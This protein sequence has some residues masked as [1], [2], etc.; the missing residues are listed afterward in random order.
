MRRTRWIGWSAVPLILLLA[1]LPA[2]AAPAAPAAGSP[3]AQVPADAPFVVYVH[4]L[5]RTQDRLETMIKNA[6]PDLGPKVTDQMRMAIKQLFQNPALMGRE[7]K[8]LVKDGAI[9]VVS[10]EMPAPG[11]NPPKVA[12]LVPVKSYAE[13]RDSVLQDDE[14]KNLKNDSAGYE[15]TIVNNEDLYFIDRKN[16]Y[17]AVTP[18]KEVAAMLAK[19]T[20]TGLD[21]KLR[22]EMS[23]KLLDADVGLYVDMAAVNKQYGDVIKQSRTT[24]EEQLE[25]NTP[26]KTVAE[27]MKRMMGPMF[28]AVQDSTALLVTAEFRPAG[29][30]LHFQAAVGEDT[31]SNSLLRDS[32]PSAITETRALPAGLMVYSAMHIRPAVLEGYGSLV[33]S[34]LADPNSEEGKALKGALDELAAAKPSLVVTASDV[35]L[36]G[37]SVWTFG[38][39]TKAADAQ[40]KLFKALKPGVTAA[41]GMLKDAPEVKAKAEKYEGFEFNSAKLTW[42]LEKMVEQQ[43]AAG[44]FNEQQKKALLDYQKSMLGEGTNI[45]FG[46]DGKS[47]LQVTAK[48]W[49]TAQALIDAYLQAKSKVGDVDAYKDARQQL[50]PDVTI[51]TMVDLPLY[52]QA[53]VE[54]I[55]PLLQAGGLPIAIPAPAGKAKT[56]YLGLDIVLQPERGSFDVWVPGSAVNEVYKMYLQNLLKGFGGT[57]A[58]GQP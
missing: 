25:K 2:P 5:E 14:R 37:L 44:Q 47:Y 48:D 46:T 31:K 41:G 54:G 13:F 49:K 7:P 35:P 53:I 20:T 51:L 32:K 12:L 56:T 27:L 4:G 10:T 42:D 30:A 29:L 15:S 17:A 22:K 18:D 52:T 57:G 43:N 1:A 6:L 34:V 58:P 21:G 8:G 26:D 33:F 39:P 24:A 38:D 45:W 16:G 3:L 55:K 19:K 23:K 40:M 36:R 28:Q 9:F 11:Q 50:P